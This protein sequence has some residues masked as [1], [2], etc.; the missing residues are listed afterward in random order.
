MLAF[1]LTRE[2]KVELEV[3]RKWL[4]VVKFALSVSS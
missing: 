2:V 3:W 1:F 4:E